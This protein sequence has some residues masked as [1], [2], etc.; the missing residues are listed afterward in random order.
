MIETKKCS[1]CFQVKKTETEFYRKLDRFQSRCKACNAE[2]VRV[3]ARKKRHP[4][5][6][7][8]RAKDRMIEK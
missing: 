3:Y 7:S 1:N 6:Q 8:L 5:G 2:V 4:W